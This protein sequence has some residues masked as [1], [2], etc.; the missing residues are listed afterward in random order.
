MKSIFPLAAVSAV[1]FALFMLFRPIVGGIGDPTVPDITGRAEPFVPDGATGMAPFANLPA[2]KP[3]IPASVTKPSAAQAAGMGI[4]NP[5]QVEQMI[6]DLVNAE[7]RK[8]QAPDL[9]VEPTLQQIARGHSND[10][11]ARGFFEHVN[12]DGQAPGD[13]VAIEHRQLIGGAG[14]NIGSLAGMDVSD[15]KKLA[16]QIMNMW[17]KSSGHRENILKPEYTHIG[18]GVAV[19]DKEVRAT[20][21][22][23]A[24]RGFLD[25]PV[26]AQVATGDTLNLSIRPFAGGQLP[27]EYDFLMPDKGTTTGKDYPIGEGKVE[28]G[29][30]VYKLRFHFPKPGGYTIYDGPLIQVK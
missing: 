28:I 13:R 25:Q 6:L 27:S 8:A 20:Q 19:K 7:R 2:P 4:T 22:F 15:Q 16:E 3:V 17:M 11:L 5:D 30:G 29:K 12:P 18:I 26:P 14:E 10:M 23:T 21:L 9:T 24:T 1:L